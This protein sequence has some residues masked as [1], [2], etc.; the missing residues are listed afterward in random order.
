MN[1]NKEKWSDVKLK[2]PSKV[3]VYLNICHSDRVKNPTSK[4]KNGEEIK[5]FNL[6]MLKDI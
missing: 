6:S 4:S 1:I 5:Q 3:R 2:F